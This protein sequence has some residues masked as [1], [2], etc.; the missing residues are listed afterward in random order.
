[1]MPI[2]LRVSPLAPFGP[3]V[4]GLPDRSSVRL[5]NVFPEAPKRSFDAQAKQRI[6]GLITERDVV[7]HSVHS[8][9]I[10]QHLCEAGNLKLLVVLA[11]E[12]VQRVTATGPKIAALR[13]LYSASSRWVR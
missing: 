2:S 13:A 11:Q 3:S 8:R 9:W 10:S 4:P 12:G 5:T 6:I 1:M 7:V